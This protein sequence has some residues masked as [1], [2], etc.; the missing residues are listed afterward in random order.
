MRDT[1]TELEVNRPR[2][3]TFAIHIIEQHRALQPPV[4]CFFGE[5]VSWAAIGDVLVCPAIEGS[6]MF[7]ENH[8]KKNAPITTL[9]E[10]HEITTWAYQGTERYQVRLSETSCTVQRYHA[11]RGQISLD[12]WRQPDMAWSTSPFAP[13]SCECNSVEQKCLWWK[14]C[15][16]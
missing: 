11:R 15:G 14:S 9:Q 8:Q 5:V 13:L 2:F 4:S 16:G 1:A 10:R 3:D 6:H 7:E 12:S